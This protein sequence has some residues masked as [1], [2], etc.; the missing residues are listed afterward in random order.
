MISESGIIA[1]LLNWRHRHSR[2]SLSHF[3]VRFPTKFKRI[4]F[5]KDRLPYNHVDVT[6]L[7]YHQKGWNHR[8]PNS[9]NLPFFRM[10]KAQ[11]YFGAEMEIL[12]YKQDQYLSATSNVNLSPA[13]WHNIK[14]LFKCDICIGSQT[15]ITAV[16][17]RGFINTLQ[18]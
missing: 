10:N 18:N 1:E 12:I 15:R 8:C 13:Q 17:N 5:F 2:F 6:D 14:I 16:G 7:V 9:P 11:G 3:W 4:I